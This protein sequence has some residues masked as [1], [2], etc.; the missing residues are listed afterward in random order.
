MTGRVM[1]WVVLL[2]SRD[3]PRASVWSSFD[4]ISPINYIIDSGECGVT[5]YCVLDQD[6]VEIY[7][8][9]L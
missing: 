4:D 8:F 7:Y 1:S 3:T 9:Q 2:C 5:R 6:S